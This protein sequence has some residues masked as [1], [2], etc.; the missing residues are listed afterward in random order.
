MMLMLVLVM[1]M[2]MMM[3]MMM[4]TAVVHENTPRTCIL[5]TYTSMNAGF[6]FHIFMSILGRTTQTNKN[7][8]GYMYVY[9][10]YMY[11]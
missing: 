9:N 11:I 2:V 1:A 10:T 5:S 3:E 4:M 8:H 7:I 6:S